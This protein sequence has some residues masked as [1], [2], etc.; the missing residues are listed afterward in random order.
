MMLACSQSV[1][2]QS[3]SSRSRASY[4]SQMRCDTV[5]GSPFTPRQALCIL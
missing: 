4:S 1:F 3:S 2:G 5:Q